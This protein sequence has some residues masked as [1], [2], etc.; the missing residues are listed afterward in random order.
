MTVVPLARIHS[1]GTSHRNSVP[2][3]AQPTRPPGG[4][5]RGDGQLRERVA[6]AL[7]YRLTGS[8]HR[9][10]EE[11]AADLAEPGR[12]LRLLQGDVGSGKTV[13]ALFAML[14]AVEAGT[15]AAT[16]SEEDAA[17]DTGTY[18]IILGGDALTGTN[19]ASVTVSIDPAST[20]ENGAGEDFTAAVIQAIADAA[21]LD[22]TISASGQTPTSIT[23]AAIATSRNRSSRLASTTRRILAADLL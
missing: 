21:G 9:A 19:T 4:S 22:A 15:Q 5:L 8:Q 1:T 23:P 7:P 14:L 13:V 16:I 20:T 18:T 6:A 11:I 3:P 10:I 2:A 17:D 12:M